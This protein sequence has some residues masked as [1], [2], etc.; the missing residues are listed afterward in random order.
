MEQILSGAIIKVY[1]GDTITIASRLPYKDSPL[2]RFPVR[3]NRID[4]P[5]L[6]SKNEDERTAAI[7]C[8]NKVS[9]LI[10]NKYVSLRNIQN[11]KYGRILADVYVNELCI[12]DLLINERYAVIYD[13]KEKKSPVS[14][15]EYKLKGEL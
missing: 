8:K 5:E 12:N 14:W 4:T 13:G 11:E 9:S 10:L 2:Y 6:K 1:D 7:E 15:L 3:L